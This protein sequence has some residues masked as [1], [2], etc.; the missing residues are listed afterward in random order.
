[1]NLIAVIVVVS[2]LIVLLKMTKADW[3]KGRQ[4]AKNRSVRTRDN[5]RRGPS[6]GD[7]PNWPDNEEDIIINNWRRKCA[8]YNIVNSVKNYITGGRKAEMNMFPYLVGLL[9]YQPPSVYQCGGSLITQRYVLTAAHCLFRYLLYI[10]K[11]LSRVSF[12]TVFSEDP[13]R[14]VY[15]WV[16]TYMLMLKQLTL[17]TTLPLRTL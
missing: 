6:I 16:P 8:K 15:I 5:L 11:S 3:T 17:Y 4:Y 14:P 2:L 1:M 13:Q 10:H 7:P 9:M 12:I